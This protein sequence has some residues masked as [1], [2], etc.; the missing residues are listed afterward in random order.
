MSSDISI[1]SNIGVVK[2]CDPLLSAWAVRRRLIDGSRERGHFAGRTCEE[3][4]ENV[5]LSKV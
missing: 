5:V 2:V 4:E 1:I 3:I